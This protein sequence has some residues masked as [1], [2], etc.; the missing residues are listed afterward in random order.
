MSTGK[1]LTPIQQRAMS[2]RAALQGEGSLKQIGMALPKLGVTPENVARAAIT[3][4]LQNPKLIE[5][6][7]EFLLR[8]IV[9]AAT[10]GLLVDGRQAHLVPFK[11]KINGQYKMTCQLM[12]DYKGQVQLIRRS[13]NVSNFYSFVIYENDTYTVQLGTDPK[14]EH[15]PCTNGKRGEP[16]MVYS[17]I[18]YK[19]GAFDFQVMT[20][21][22]VEYVRDHY[23]KRDNDGKFSAA[24]VDRFTEMMRKTCIHNHAKTADLSYLSA[25]AIQAD[26]LR[27]AGKFQEADAVFEQALSTL[28]AETGTA[29]DAPVGAISYGGDDEDPGQ[30]NDKTTNHEPAPPIKD[31]FEKAVKNSRVKYGSMDNVYAFVKAVA[32]DNNVTA[33]AVLVDA[34]KRIAEFM[35]K[36]LAWNAPKGQGKEPAGIIDTVT[37]FQLSHVNAQLPRDKQIRLESVKTEEDIP[38]Y[39]TLVNQIAMDLGIKILLP[40]NCRLPLPASN[41][42]V[43]FEEAKKNAPSFLQ[44]EE[45]PQATGESDFDKPI[46]REHMNIIT[47]IGIG[48]GVIGNL[49]E[50]LT[51]KALPLFNSEAPDTFFNDMVCAIVEKVAPRTPGQTDTTVCT[52]EQ[53]NIIEE[54]RKAMGADASGL[55][56]WMDKEFGHTRMIHITYG[57]LP[58]ALVY[59]AENRKK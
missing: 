39:L 21:E 44:G 35:K 31:A 56:R 45:N 52:H 23:S 4:I 54:F 41:V 30:V 19:D 8:A 43:P 33:E 7:Y 57:Q 6:D 40:E 11:T 48:L 3:C 12:I 10:F 26:S 47:S 58:K 29:I 2:I 49:N 16:I 55:F 32:Q 42:W 1:E 22:E 15:T 14:I 59:L 36:Y 13:P 5:C 53:L 51:E 38:A 20:K 24:W 17:V 25:M 34:T 50:I 9:Q 18:R 37:L 46:T 27:E 28:E